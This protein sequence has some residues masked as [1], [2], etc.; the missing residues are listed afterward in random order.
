MKLSRTFICSLAIMIAASS[1]AFAQNRDLTPD[2]RLHEKFDSK[3]AK[4]RDLVVWLPPAYAKETTRRFPTLYMHDGDS[5]FV[6]WRLDETAAALIAN[7][8]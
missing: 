2:H 3:F 7:K 6:N 4:E 1:P 5:T 8:R